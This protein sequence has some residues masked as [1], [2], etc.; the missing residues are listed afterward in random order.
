MAAAHT[1]GIQRRVGTRGVTYRVELCINSKRTSKSFKRKSDAVAWKR[2]TELSMQE[3]TWARTS[4]AQRHTFAELVDQFIELEKPDSTLKL[5]IGAC[6]VWFLFAGERVARMSS[7]FLQL[8]I[9][10]LR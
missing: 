9:P 5:R 1:T 8:L 10:V 2:Q 7:A 6:W 3:G 4:K